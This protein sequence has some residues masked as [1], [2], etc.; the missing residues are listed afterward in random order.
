MTP[1]VTRLILANVA[2]FA[3]TEYFLPGS[4]IYL[5]LIPSMMLQHPWTVFT[6]MFVHAGWMHILFNMIALYFF[7]PRL[8]LRLGGGR[9]LALYF[10]SG[11]GG[12]A[13]SLLTPDVAIVGASGAIMGVLVGYAR[14]WPHDKIYLWAIVPI[15][16]RVLLILFVGF[17]I[18]GGLG[19]VE[20]H[21][22]HFAHLGGVAVGY[23]Y[24]RWSEAHSPAARFKRQ[25]APVAPTPPSAAEVDRWRRIRPDDLHPVNRAEYDRIRAKLDA[26][27]PGGLTPAERAF[28][29]RFSAV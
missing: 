5:A 22:A 11:L 12:A 13:L 10:L 26:A 8:E 25:A 4:A 1:W 29:D 7:G 15:E 2:V 9:F 21:V 6:Y 17:E 14:Y 3:V 19:Y 16:A 24:L 20:P 27:G 23:L 28:L 18:L